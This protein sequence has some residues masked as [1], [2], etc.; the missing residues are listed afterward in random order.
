[1]FMAMSESGYAQSSVT[2][3]GLIDDAISYG[4]NTAPGGNVVAMTAGNLGGSRW[5]LKGSEDLGDG[6]K[7]VFQLENG[8]NPNTGSSGA[9]FGRQA[10]VGVSSQ[11]WGT[12]T[13]G[14]QYVPD[15][16]IVQSIT[17]DNSFGAI[18]ATPGDVDN[19]DNS[20][21]GNNSIKYVGPTLYGLQAEGLYAVGGQAG[22][23][24][25]G[26]SWG[27]AL[28]YAV[29]S[30]SLAASYQ[31]YSG[32]HASGTRVFTTV[33]ADNI[34]YSPVTAAY[35]SAASIKIARVAAR[36]TFGPANVGASYSNSRYT[37]DGQSAFLNTQTYNAANVFGTYQMTPVVLTS[38]GYTYLKS[39]GNSSANYH[40]VNLGL[41]YALSKQSSIYVIA[42]WEKAS[43]T[44]TPGGGAAQ[45]SIGS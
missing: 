39:S 9:G 1:M 28:S 35:A 15:T 30:L 14:R 22:M 37:S 18:F 17:G 12:L 33:T 38:L 20:I 44:Q 19:Y 23:A 8:F 4:H 2:L 3:Y 41:S 43:G 25:S 21:R 42:A 29:T 40:E 24:G 27:A 10:Y 13:A 36:Y 26:R 32:G 6:L 34:F 31:Y 7:V 11:Q 16:D 45:A 5:G